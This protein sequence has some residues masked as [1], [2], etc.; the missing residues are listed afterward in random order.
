MPVNNHQESNGQEDIAENIKSQ[1]GQGGPF[2]CKLSV[3]YGSE[4]MQ[5]LVFALRTIMQLSQQQQR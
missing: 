2:D 5:F 1:L 3:R 4:S